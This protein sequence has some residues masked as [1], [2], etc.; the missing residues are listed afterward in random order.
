MPK[1]VPRFDIG[2]EGMFKWKYTDIQVT[3]LFPR[4][5]FLDN[6]AIL[7]AVSSGLTVE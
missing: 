4:T 6:N 5:A 7:E 1:C 3:W 2:P